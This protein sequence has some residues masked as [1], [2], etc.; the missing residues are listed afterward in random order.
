MAKSLTSL[1]VDAVLAG[2]RVFPVRNV[3]DAVHAGY[4]L[5]Q[6]PPVIVLIEHVNF[7][8][9]GNIRNAYSLLA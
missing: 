1:L 9:G 4:L 3:S 8:P 2:T 6:D 5:R 7:Q